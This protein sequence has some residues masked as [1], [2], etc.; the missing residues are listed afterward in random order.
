VAIV[1]A[2]SVSVSEKSPKLQ[3]RVSDL[4]GG[5]LGKMTVSLDSAK[6]TLDNSVL[7]KKESC[8]AVSGDSSLY[9]INFMKAKPVRGFYTVTLSATPSKAD[10]KF[11][12]LTGAEIQVKVTTQVTIENVEVGVADR[13]QTTAAKTTK[14]QHPNKAAN[15]L[16]A[17]HHQ[18]LLIKFMLKDKSSGSLMKA[19]QTFVRLTNYKTKQEIIF[20]AKADSSQ[21]YKFNLDI[22]ESAKDFGWLS[23]KYQLELIVG[24]AVIENPFS[25]HMAD[26]TLVFPEGAAPIKPNEDLFGKL[27]EIKH[28][29]RPQEKR[30]HPLISNAFTVLVFVPILILL[31]LWMKLGINVSNFSGSISAIGFHVCLGIVFVLYFL[32]WIKLDMFQTMRYLGIITIPLFIC[33]NRLLNS[34]ASKRK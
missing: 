5:N 20:T 26:M 6:N 32:Y 17:D 23:G 27:P 22:G 19:H 10:S 28:M 33:G 1:L 25:W 21:T 29:F 3:V 2:S 11:I 9:E 16:E 30:P 31:G 7:F 14:L 4:I 13:D 24:D 18:K 34:I 12:G 8:S 15:T